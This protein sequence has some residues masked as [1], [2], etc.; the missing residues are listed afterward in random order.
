MTS[1]GEKN[2]NSWFELT[3]L[4]PGRFFIKN[5]HQRVVFHNQSM[6]D[7]YNLDK[8]AKEDMAIGANA[9]EIITNLNPLH[10]KLAAKCASAVDN[11]NTIMLKERRAIIF[12][13]IIPID[14]QPSHI[15]NHKGPVF[16]AHGYIIGHFGYFYSPHIFADETSKALFDIY[17]QAQYGLVTSKCE[18]QGHVQDQNTLINLIN[19][20]E[21]IEKKLG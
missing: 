6:E 12:E 19:C 18:A 2:N 7:Y 16:D 9:H 14:G 15:I 20:I 10:P 5:L 11:N 4:L 1:E 17:Q 13:E 3:R 8:Q 21:S